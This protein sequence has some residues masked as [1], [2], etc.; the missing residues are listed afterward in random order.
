MRDRRTFLAQC[1][2]EIR[3]SHQVHSTSA[4][5]LCNRRTPC[6]ALVRV[7]CPAGGVDVRHRCRIDPLRS[8]DTRV[9][10]AT[11]TVRAVVD[12]AIDASTCPAAPPSCGSAF[13]FAGTCGTFCTLT[14]SWSDSR[15][16]CSAPW[17]LALLDTTA[18]LEA[19]PTLNED[20][21]VGAMQGGDNIWRWRGTTVV[22]DDAWSGGTPPIGGDSCARVQSG[23]HL[24][25]S[26]ACGDTLSFVCTVP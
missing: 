7:T 16:H 26:R 2:V 24:L 13:S 4:V 18:K 8:H 14:K 3:R 22:R 12:A 6:V 10:W 25:D 15:D 21:W 1:P 5:V 17:G 20:H 9:A 19:V 11:R 23:Q